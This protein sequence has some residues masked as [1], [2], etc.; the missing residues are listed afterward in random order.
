MI[1]KVTFSSGRDLEARLNEGSAKGWKLIH[2]T[3]APETI[4]YSGGY[5]MVWELPPPG[6]EKAEVE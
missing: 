2:L 4:D 6:H 5:T 3:E 1:Y